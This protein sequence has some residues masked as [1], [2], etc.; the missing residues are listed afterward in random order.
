MTELRHFRPRPTSG[1][2]DANRASGAH[3]TVV[4]LAHTGDFVYTA[5]LSPVPEPVG[6]HC[7]TIRSRWQSAR[8]PEA[9]QVR[10]RVCLDDDGLQAL[11]GLLTTAT[12]ATTAATAVGGVGDVR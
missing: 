8:D 7:L 6:G 12:T 2:H 5:E 4:T 9:E 1:V 3:S 10:L 11:A